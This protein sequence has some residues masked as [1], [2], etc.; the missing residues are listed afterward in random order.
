MLALEFGVEEY[1]GNWKSEE[2]GKFC[3]AGV[4]VEIGNKRQTWGVP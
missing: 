3:N 4:A 1:S 2:L